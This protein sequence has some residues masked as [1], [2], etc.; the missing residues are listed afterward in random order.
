MGR[1]SYIATKEECNVVHTVVCCKCRQKVQVHAEPGKM[2]DGGYVAGKFKYCPNCGEKWDSVQRQVGERRKRPKVEALPVDH[3]KWVIARRITMGSEHSPWRDAEILGRMSAMSA[4]KALQAK[5]KASEEEYNGYF[6]RAGEID[7]GDKRS[8][9]EYMLKKLS[10]YPNY[11]FP[12]EVVNYKK[13]GGI[14]KLRV[15][16]MLE[17]R[18]Q[19]M[20]ERAY[21]AIF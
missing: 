9:Y 1:W 14:R 18:K 12:E 19:V 17:K 2:R 21:N 6:R 4:Y 7:L 8:K 16:S 13:L 11:I 10:G 15:S 5:R 20:A 3:C